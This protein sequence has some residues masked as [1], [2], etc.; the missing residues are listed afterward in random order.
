MSRGQRRA[1]WAGGLAA[2]VLATATACGGSQA[3]PRTSSSRS[4]L[5]AQAIQFIY[6]TT[7][8]GELS[9]AH[10]HGRVTVL[11]FVT[12]FDLASQVQAERLN[13]TL[14]RHTPRINAAAVMLEAPKYAILADTFRTALKLD[15][16]VAIADDETRRGSGPFGS[17]SRVPTTVV[18]DRGGREVWR[19]SGVI[20][21]REL[22]RV[23][24]A[25]Q[26]RY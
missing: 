12:S 18:L 8:G 2:L 17:V 14:H 21:A 25:A 11:L 24:S 10:T 4:R 9:S 19:K 23:L 7:E 20:P 22:E 3:E 15:Y 1:F 16:P 26:P 5:S 6:G 13:E